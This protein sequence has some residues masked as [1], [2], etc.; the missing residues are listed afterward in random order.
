MQSDLGACAR[1]AVVRA[2]LLWLTA[3]YVP[4]AQ[5]LQE[6]AAEGLAQGL[7]F[8]GS[9]RLNLSSSSF[10]AVSITQAEQLARDC[11]SSGIELDALFLQVPFALPASALT[12]LK[13]SFPTARRWG[14][15]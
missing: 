8:L 2:R 5:T 11:Q 14:A 3:R 15:R 10:G 6:A 4:Q 9:R 1:A 12:S 13:A 7:R